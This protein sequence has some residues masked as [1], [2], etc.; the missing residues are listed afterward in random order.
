[1]AAVGR[2]RYAYLASLSK[3]VEDRPLFRLI[4]RRRMQR[5][6]EV[7]VGSIERALNLIGV[8]QRYAA[9]QEVRYAAV[10]WFEERDASLPKLSFI[11]AHRRLGASG[12]KVRLSPGGPAAVEALANAL[13]RTDLILISDAVTD[14]QL[15]GVW[16]F[17]PRMCHEGTRVLRLTPQGDSQT[18]VPVSAQ[19]ISQRA[20]AS[21]AR[22]AA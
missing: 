3:P 12:A 17:F 8:C 2:F 20:N 21:P 6:L 18:Y 16:Y 10:D 13:P 22:L 9:G 1:M 11:D 14:A 19:E 7:G 5:V 4:R 15:A